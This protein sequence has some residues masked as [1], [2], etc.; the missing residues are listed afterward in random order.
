MRN[1]KHKIW[2]HLFIHWLL[3]FLLVVQIVNKWGKDGAYD[4]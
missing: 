4:E 2:T 3:A 1:N